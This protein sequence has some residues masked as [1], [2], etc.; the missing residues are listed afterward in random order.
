MYILRKRLSMLLSLYCLY[1]MFFKNYEIQNYMHITVYLAGFNAQGTCPIAFTCVP[2][3]V[4]ITISHCFVLFKQPVI[5]KLYFEVVHRA[6]TIFSYIA[7]L[8]F[9]TIT[10]D[11][12]FTKML[13]H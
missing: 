5:W 11:H 13:W 9:S 6:V 12:Y 10:K 3:D 7:L 1:K 2:I 8:L 4:F